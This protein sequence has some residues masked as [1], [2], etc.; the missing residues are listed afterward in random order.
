M[1]LLSL[2]AAVLGISAAEKAI[3]IF[4]RWHKSDEEEKYELE[5][6]FYFTY[7]TVSVVLGIRLFAV[8]LYFWTMQ[9][10]V[11]MVPGAMCLW[12]VF[13]TLP[14]FCWSAL[15]LKLLLPTL[16]VGWLILARING[17]C[18][19]NPILRNLMGFYL[20]MLPLLVF[21]SLLDFTIFYSI[22]PVEVSCCASAIDEWPR[23]L[24]SLI[25][26]V[27]G[28]M[29]LLV[30]FLSLSSIYVVSSISSVKWRRP[31]WLT[32]LLS[33]VLIPLTILTFTEVLT[34]WILHLPM[35][36]CPFCLFY[37][38]PAAFFSL[39]LLWV[40]FSS[41]WWTLITERLGRKDRE[42]N[43]VESFV[44]KNLWKICGATNLIAIT[45]IVILT[46]L[47]HI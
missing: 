2:S 31:E 39:S 33:L 26:G 19:R 44:R 25:I 36:H 28:Q 3:E 6:Q 42:S 14:E 12:G 38:I 37:T 45:I 10:F 15:A 4:R 16:Y 35:H 20:V 18:K 46:I 9:S 7:A 24:S 17:L 1:L 27:S 34:P 40:S 43:E 11:P 5:K 32:R 21:D 23:P 8:P 30:L 13:N 47:S 29:I 41:P 22:R